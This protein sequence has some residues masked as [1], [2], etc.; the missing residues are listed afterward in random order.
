MK[1]RRLKRWV[2]DLIIAAAI[3]LTGVTVFQLTTIRTRQTTPAGEYT[4]RGGI[5][6]VCSGPKKVADYLGV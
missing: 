5:L 6:K 1:R 4:C 3:I 2:K